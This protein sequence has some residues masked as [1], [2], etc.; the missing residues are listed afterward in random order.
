MGLSL[1]TQASGKKARH[2][3]ATIVFSPSGGEARS[4]RHIAASLC[5]SGA[6]GFC[7]L[8]VK[9]NNILHLLHE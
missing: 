6:P 9:K 1:H 2:I 8:P 3:I 7:A 4:I 5:D